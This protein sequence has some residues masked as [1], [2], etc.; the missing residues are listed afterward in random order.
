MVTRDTLALAAAAR[1]AEATRARVDTRC[2][3]SPGLRGAMPGPRYAAYGTAAGASW[4]STP[5]V[6]SASG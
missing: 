4:A 1:E 6:H 3:C 5:P 2:D